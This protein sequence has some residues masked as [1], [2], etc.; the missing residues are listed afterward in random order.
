MS[1]FTLAISCLTTSNLL[2]FV[3]LTFQ[4]PMQYCSLQHRTFL[5][6][7]VT[8]TTGYCFCFGS[9][10]SF[11]LELFL[12]WSPVHVG[13]LLT[14]GDHCLFTLFIFVYFPD[15]LA[16]QFQYFMNGFS[17][18]DDGL[19]EP[20]TS[21]KSC[22]LH[23]LWEFL[24][25]DTFLRKHFMACLTIYKAGEPI[26]EANAWAAPNKQDIFELRKFYGRIFFFFF[27]LVECG[28]QLQRLRKVL[29]VI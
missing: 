14:W 16:S 20:S 3:D 19:R 4:V 26:Q 13:H 8:F 28:D 23:E 29:T 17:T 11:F 27:F 25:A 21:M 6:S 18:G 5:L 9:I 7:P 22:F 24:K 15:F 2:W 10:P 12:H 1:I